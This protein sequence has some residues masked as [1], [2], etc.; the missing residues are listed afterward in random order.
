MLKKYLLSF[1]QDRAEIFLVILG[2]LLWSLTMVKSGI[3]YS[4]G[5]GFWGPN[6]H[7]GI[8]HIA[9]SES[10][11][12]GGWGIPVF[13]GELIKNYHIG[14]DLLLAVLHKLSFIPVVNLYF[15]ILPPIL[16]FLIGLFVYL[17]IKSWTGSKVSAFL[18]TFFVYFGG[19]L[20]WLVTL[21][22][23]GQI[24]GESL[25][26]SQQS[27]STLVNPPFALSLVLIFAGLIILEKGL[28]TEN[29]KL[30][31]LATF[32]FGILVQ[33]KVYAGILI[34]AGLFSAGVFRMLRRE[35]TTLLK[36]FIG[37]LVV[38]I[39]IFSPLS[40]GISNTIIFRPFWFLE[41]MMSTPDHFYWPRFAEAMV[42]YSLGGIWLKAI[43]AYGFSLAVFVIGN[44][45]TRV[46]ALM[47]FKKKGFRFASYQYIDVLIMTIIILG[48]LIPLFVIQSGTP[49]NT[50]QFMYYSLMFS[51]ILAGIWLANF[52][53]TN[54]N[55]NRYL[56]ALLIVLLTIP[57]TIGTLW[58]VYLPPRPPAKVSNQELEALYF[59][60]KLPNGIVLTQPFNKDAADAAIN[61]PPRS[62]YL[63]E[64]T[65]YVSAFSEKP[66]YLEDE[67]N[68]NITG[69]DWKD[70][71]NKELSYFSGA[72]KSE[73]G[74]F[75]KD[76]GISYVY[77]LKSENPPNIDFT[78][79][80]KIY[81]NQEVQ[82]FKRK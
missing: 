65:A 32:L 47:W 20:G 81:E 75:I 37:T 34:L 52:I 44:L 76:N 26:W 60:K 35:G 14:F 80:N 66:V 15:Q 31:G 64:S 24:G 48:L 28:R 23:D 5:A 29:K 30:L 74:S 36:V 11:T 61:N 58:Y 70:R 9:L 71:R 17:F 82:I 1:F 25:F 73:S 59:L 62:L 78:N 56:T 38:S 18:G 27:V 4:Y 51:G 46:L 57:T 19:S 39:L 6:G 8:W 3:N 45:G 10:L 54:L 22:R 43:L 41:E 42:N 21:I 68:L 16:A 53:E 50:I 77:L 2:T 13:S 79:L 72:D 69:Y 40:K 12:K 49:W 63:Y 7:D 67:V 55:I 33:I